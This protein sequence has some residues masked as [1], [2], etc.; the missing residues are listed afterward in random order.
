MVGTAAIDLAWVAAG[1]LDASLTLSNKP[2][3]MAAGALVV[4][5]A[6]GRVLDPTA[7]T[8]RPLDRHPRRDA[9]SA[10]RAAHWGPLGG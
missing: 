1:K 9:A 5:E 8:T 2:W 6:G 10:R 3:D 4:Q 7:P